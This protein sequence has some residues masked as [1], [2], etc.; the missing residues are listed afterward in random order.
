MMNAE[1]VIV[2]YEDVARITAEMLA[3]ARS[4]RWDELISLEQHCA[5]RVRTLA[6]GESPVRLSG[7]LRNRKIAML[8]QILADDREIRDL[9]EP[10]MRQV[11]QVM[12][13]ITERRL[14]ATYGGVQAN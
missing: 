5:N 3:A 14:S 2:A 9:T 11:S 6:Q 12:S 1:D 4:S 13:S 8:R 7:E 10:W